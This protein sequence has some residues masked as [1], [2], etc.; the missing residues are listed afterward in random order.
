M[1]NDKVLDW[2]S[3]DIC[4]D[5]ATKTIF[6]QVTC[7]GANNFKAVAFG[8]DLGSFIDRQVAIDRVS[9]VVKVGRFIDPRD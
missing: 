9:H 8:R 2:T 7:N 5:P 4:F 6:G 1:N 3:N